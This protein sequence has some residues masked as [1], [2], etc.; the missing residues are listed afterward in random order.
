M[1]IITRKEAIEKGLKR[2]FTGKPCKYGHVSEKTCPNGTCVDCREAHDKK[3]KG[4]Q[5]GYFKEYRKKNKVKLAEY[6]K[7]YHVKNYINLK[8]K[9]N[10]YKSENKESIDVVSRKWREKNPLPFFIRNSLKRIIN[11]GKVAGRNKK[12]FTATHTKI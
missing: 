10:K 5:K 12:K 1:E 4:M 2:Y 7:K 3:R 6:Q 8:S 11:N 9:R